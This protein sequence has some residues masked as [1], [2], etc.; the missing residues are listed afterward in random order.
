MPAMFLHFS[1]PHFF[2]L[3][4][5]R[6]D[7]IGDFRGLLAYLQWGKQGCPEDKLLIWANSNGP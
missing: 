2:F 1:N 7:E 6:G 4:S 5:N 3:P